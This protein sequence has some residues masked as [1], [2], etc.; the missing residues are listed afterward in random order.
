MLHIRKRPSK[1]SEVYLDQ[2]NGFKAKKLSR[3]D[4]NRYYTTM[5]G[6]IQENTKVVSIPKGIKKNVYVYLKKK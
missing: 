2:S 5:K 4:T 1:Q 3:R 6:S